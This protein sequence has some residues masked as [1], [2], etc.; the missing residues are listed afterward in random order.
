MKITNKQIA[1]LN[2]LI[3]RIVDYEGFTIVPPSCYWNLADA[4][5]DVIQLFDFEDIGIG[6]SETLNSNPLFTRVS[7]DTIYYFDI[8]GD[9]STC[10]NLEAVLAEEKE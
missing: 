7:N 3:L 8:Y 9:S 2:I 6:Y 5:N 1:T 4:M 10:Y